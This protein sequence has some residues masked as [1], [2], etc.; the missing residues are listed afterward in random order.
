MATEKVSWQ[1][2]P[3]LTCLEEQWAELTGKYSQDSA[4]ID[5]HFTEI[6]G[7][8]TSS[9]RHYHNTGHIHALFKLAKQYEDFLQDKDVVGFSIFYHDIVYKVTRSDNEE[10]S[11]VRAEKDLSDLKIPTDKIAIVAKYIHA[12]KQHKL[13]DADNES[14][15]AWFLDFDMAILGADWD[16]YLEYTRQIRKEYSVYPDFLYN[17]ARRKFLQSSLSASNI[18]HTTLFRTY[19]EQEARENIRKELER[20]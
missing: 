15:L 3:D 14:D 9:S 1:M 2:K 7:A 13:N 4:L 18:F 16:R 5:K 12:T 6:Q 20:L 17:Q 19:H 8:Y 11:A 10:K